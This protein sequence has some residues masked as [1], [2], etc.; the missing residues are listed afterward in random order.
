M[1]FTPESEINNSSE[2]RI[3]AFDFEALAK[4]AIAETLDRSRGRV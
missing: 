4:H 2:R 1:Q 3:A